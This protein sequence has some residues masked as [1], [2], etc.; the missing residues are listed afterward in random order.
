MAEEFANIYFPN[1]QSL[2]IRIDGILM[3]LTI[4]VQCSQGHVSASYPRAVYCSYYAP[5][6]RAVYCVTGGKN[7]QTELTDRRDYTYLWKAYST[8]N[9]SF[10]SWSNLNTCNVQANS[11]LA[12]TDTHRDW[13]WDEIKG[14]THRR[15]CMA[16][17]FL[18]GL[19]V[20]PAFVRA[21][22][23]ATGDRRRRPRCRLRW[24][25]RPRP[26][27]RLKPD[28][29]TCWYLWLFKRGRIGRRVSR[30][31]SMKKLTTSQ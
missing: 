13:S 29:I 27:P 1:Y 9:S 22:G 5:Y 19:L 30:T 21:D 24:R 26:G 11:F 23:A 7:V 8:V 12:K 16:A 20:F 2:P 31:Y 18:L 6:P 25:P 3:H 10:I 15:G 4:E 28:K 14:S 17:M